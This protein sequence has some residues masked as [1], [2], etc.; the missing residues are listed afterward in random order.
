[1]L[2]PPTTVTDDLQ[3]AFLLGP[4]ESFLRQSGKRIREAMLRGGYAMAGGAGDPP[5]AL[6]DSIECLHAGSLVIDDIQDD[7]PVRRGQPA[8]HAQIG[9]PLAI[10]AGNWMYFRALEQ[11][12]SSDLPPARRGQLLSLMVSAGRRC[13]EGQALD[14]AA[15]L[16]EVPMANWSA[17]ATRISRDK[18][19]CLVSLAMSMGAI[20]AGARGPL[21]RVIGRF[22]YRCGMTLQMRND[23]EELRQLAALTPAETPP[24]HALRCDDLRHERITWPWVWAQRLD[25]AWTVSELAKLKTRRRSDNSWDT[26]SN[27]QGIAHDLV[28]RVGQAADR[29][30]K[31]RID[32]QIRLLSEHIVDRDALA[33]LRHSLHPIA[34]PTRQSISVSPGGDD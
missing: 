27:L 10:N 20:A 12:S 18:T 13:H 3:Q 1:M 30:I 17:V 33:N 5:A 34:V 4:C 19:G 21:L 23:L 14:L 32:K 11:I 22:A 6:I 29:L 16:S 24:A 7:S 28:S 31:H 26:Q 25:T 9:V 15:K 2:I 8:M